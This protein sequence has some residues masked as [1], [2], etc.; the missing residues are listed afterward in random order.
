VTLSLTQSSKN[1]LVGGRYHLIKQIGVG[2]TSQVFEAI[3]HLT[4]E[5]VAIKIITLNKAKSDARTV[6]RFMRE[7]RLSQEVTHQGIVRILDAWIDEQQRCC[8][9]MEYL[10][11]VNMRD[12]IRSREVTR[13]D[14]F[15]WIIKILEPLEVAHRASIIHRDLKPENIFIH[16]PAPAEKDT[17]I[18]SE[19]YYFDE[20]IGELVLCEDVSIDASEMD[21]LRLE[22]VQSIETSFDILKLLG[23]QFESTQVKILD[24]G[25]SRT[26]MEPSVTQTGHFVGTPLYMSPEQVFSPKSCEAL[27]DIWSVGV[28][29]YETLTNTVP[30]TGDTLPMVCTSIKEANISLQ[31][32]LDE[33]PQLNNLVETVMLC[34]ERD[35]DQRIQSAA[36]L[37]YRL[38][39]SFHVFAQT[40]LAKETVVGELHNTPSTQV[41]LGESNISPTFK[42]DIEQEALL[43]HT[44]QSQSISVDQPQTLQLTS[45]AIHVAMKELMEL[46]PPS[47]ELD[48]NEL[49]SNELDSNEL[50]SNELDSNELGSVQS[51]L[52]D[53]PTLL[54][55]EKSPFYSENRDWLTH[56]AEEIALPDV[57]EIGHQS[58]HEKPIQ[59]LLDEGNNE[60]TN[61]KALHTSL[62]PEEESPIM[63]ATTPPHALFEDLGTQQ[64]IK[65]YKKKKKRA[66]VWVVISLFIFGIGV[67]LL[68][69]AFRIL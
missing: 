38:D 50:D 60:A 8:L 48:S 15:R 45:D 61:A 40:A 4:Q 68:I 23:D 52:A 35:V 19:Q 66:D 12:A 13:F 46:S 7:A 57:I 51:N 54:T 21:A 33:Y 47:I 44:L 69:R 53:L 30:F 55:K 16:L 64:L 65:R 1:E 56:D 18:S 3:H 67:G 17:M 22:P 43:D 63:G 6:A 24:F 9:V 41:T 10:N 2:G 27:T 32:L 20:D 49:D 11:G 62:M 26:L 58:S 37:K 39:Q 42:G 28:M 5:R 31:P 36:E 59:H 34:L 14:L 29:L 25:L